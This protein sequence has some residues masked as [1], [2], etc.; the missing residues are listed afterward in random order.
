MKTR[1]EPIDSQAAFQYK[2][3]YRQ[4]KGCY[5]KL[6]D[7]SVIYLKGEYEEP[8]EE[9]DF[10]TSDFKLETGD[11]RYKDVKIE[12]ELLYVFPEWEVNINVISKQKDN[13][14]RYADRTR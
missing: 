11:H 5:L 9:K 1:A 8:T 2:D 14:D 12:L 3:L 13:I 4:L 10:S 7:G 6:V